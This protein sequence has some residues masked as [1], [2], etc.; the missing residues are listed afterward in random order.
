MKNT[1]KSKLILAVVSFINL[2]AP[3]VSA[4]PTLEPAVIIGDIILPPFFFPFDAKTFHGSECQPY[5]GSQSG[6]F[7]YYTNRMQN[8]STSVRLTTCP[9]V[10]DNTT[11]TTGTLGT[12]IYVNNVAGQSLSCTLYSFDSHGG[13]VASNTK[14]TTL[15]GKQTL[16]P[17]V[18]LS[19]DMGN[20]SLYC[21]LPKGASI[22]SYKVKEWLTDSTKRTD[23]Y[24]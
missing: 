13:W 15:G 9:I 24:N 19:K 2:Q 8:V 11:N 20:Y 17:D 3:L 10:R 4:A 18:N 12:E 22:F 1:L 16:Y 6:D 23:W 14:S 5:Y 21:R 7:N